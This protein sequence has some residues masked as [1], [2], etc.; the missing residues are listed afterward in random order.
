MRKTYSL[1]GGRW[2]SL[3]QSRAASCTALAP[4]ADSA[5][6]GWGSCSSAASLA[7]FKPWSLSQ[8][9]HELAGI[10]PLALLHEQPWVPFLA[11]SAHSLAKAALTAEQLLPGR[12]QPLLLT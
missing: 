5:A 7:C 11:E 12:R 1:T 10:D 8:E 3:E 2:P 9:H 6:T 4:T